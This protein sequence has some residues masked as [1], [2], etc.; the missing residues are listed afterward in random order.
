MWI[1]TLSAPLEQFVLT[2]KRIYPAVQSDPLVYSLGK[3]VSQISFDK[4]AHEV[5][6]QQLIVIS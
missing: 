6:N 3:T 1:K 2:G 4:V 5:A